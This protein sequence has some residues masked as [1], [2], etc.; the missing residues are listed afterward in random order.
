[1]TD[2]LAAILANLRKVQGN[3][4][5]GRILARADGRPMNLDNSS[6]RT[7]APTLAMARIPWYG[8]YSLRR[9]FGTSL[10]E[11]SDSM[12]T[13]SRGLRNSKDVAAKHYVKPVAVLP[14]VRKAA[15][16]ASRKL[17]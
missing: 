17:A 14:D 16:A 7:I 2:E 1:M 5:S 3:P 6:K 12:D 15:A 13:A 4:I 9:F 8:F 11:N 10:R